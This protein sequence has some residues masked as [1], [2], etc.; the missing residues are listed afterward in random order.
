MKP[1]L[2]HEGYAKSLRLLADWW[3]AHPEVR[4]PYSGNISYWQ[5]DTKEQAATLVRAFGSCEKNYD[6]EIFRVQKSF[7][8][9]TADFVLYRD[10]VCV[11]K[12]VGVETIPATFVEAHTIPAT[13]KEIVEW[14]CEPILSSE[15][16]AANE[17]AA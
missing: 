17:E 4:L 13:T 7:G 5:L 2:T 15:P 1:A 9:I 6:E 8:E 10:K 11:R 14:E 16:E 3:E 12:V